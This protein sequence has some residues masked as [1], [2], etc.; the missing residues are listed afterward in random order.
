MAIRSFIAIEVPSDIQESLGRIEERLR[1]A[2]APVGWV[3][4]D[5]IHLTTKFLGYVKEEDL[6]QVCEVMK[7]AARHTSPFEL[8]VAGLGTFPPTG[9]PRVVWAGV[10]GE[11]EPLGHLVEEIEQG[12]ADAVGVQ[13]EHRPYHPHLTLGRVKSAKN[14]ERL[15]AAMVDCG[16]AE[17]GSFSAEGITLFM[18]QL[19]REGSVYTRM[20]EMKF[21]EETRET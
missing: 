10:R 6:P 12:V 2:G 20:A 5:N 18:S 14:A 4:P 16:A 13:P 21:E 7:S 8:E 1:S 11:L 9:A 19:D 17:L 3:N 15:R